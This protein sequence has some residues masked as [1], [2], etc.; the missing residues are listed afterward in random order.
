[1]K[2]HDRKVVFSSGKDDWRT[3]PDLFA[4]LDAEFHFTVDAAANAEN[5]L[6]ERWWGPGGEI[7]DA[8]ATRWHKETCWLNPPY[9]RVAAFVSIADFWLPWARTV[10]LIPA[11]TDTRWWHEHIWDRNNHQP[12]EGVQVRFLKGRLKFS[13]SPNPAPFPSVIV[14]FGA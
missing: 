4:A 5:H 11:R 3:P 10:M 8:L 7:D 1:M 14:V 13:G 2:A 9:S 6:C 12:H